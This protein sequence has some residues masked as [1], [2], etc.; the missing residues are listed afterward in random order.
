MNETNY[1]AVL[2]RIF[3]T[4]CKIKQLATSRTKCMYEFVNFVWA[5]DRKTAIISPVHI[6]RKEKTVLKL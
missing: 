3:T 2:S 6:L 4:C 1:C 5:A